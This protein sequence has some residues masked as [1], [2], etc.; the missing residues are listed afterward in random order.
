MPQLDPIKTDDE[1][2]NV[3]SIAC[4]QEKIYRMYC[5]MGKQ[6]V[7]IPTHPV[8]ATQTDCRQ[9]AYTQRGGTRYFEKDHDMPNPNTANFIAS[10]HGLRA[11]VTR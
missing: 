3:K 1:A 6:F 7:T 10:I 5:E 9:Y 2:P 4:L 8:S 11:R